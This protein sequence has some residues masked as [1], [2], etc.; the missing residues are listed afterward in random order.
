MAVSRALNIVKGEQKVR[1]KLEVDLDLGGL[2]SEGVWV[3]VGIERGGVVAVGSRVV[4]GHGAESMG[5]GP[6]FD[7]TAQP[8]PS[9]N[10][11]SPGCRGWD[12]GWRA[13]GE[14]GGPEPDRRGGTLMEFPNLSASVSFL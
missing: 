3:L 10:R 13:W 5:G 9:G 11:Q 4:G 12:I 14:A 8:L 7:G 1:W 6:P 2:V